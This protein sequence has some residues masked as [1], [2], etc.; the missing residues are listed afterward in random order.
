MTMRFTQLLVLEQGHRAVDLGRCCQC[1]LLGFNGKAPALRIDVDRFGKL[2]TGRQSITQIVQDPGNQH[3]LV[4]L[5]RQRQ[6]FGQMFGGGFVFPEQVKGV[7][8][9]S[10][11]RRREAA[12]TGLFG[13]FERGLQ[14]ALRATDLSFLLKRMREVDQRLALLF[15]LPTLFIPPRSIHPVRRG[16]GKRTLLKLCRPL[17]HFLRRRDRRR[18]R[19]A[20]QFQREPARRPGQSAERKH[21]R[22]S[23]SSTASGHE[24]A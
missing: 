20:K 24:R 17:S 14:R 15:S 6:S 18:T 5:T 23:A 11:N 19:T 13:E 7:A 22:G 1:R 3:R 4:L 12:L 8:E 9:L 16:L 21:P 10:E 2:P